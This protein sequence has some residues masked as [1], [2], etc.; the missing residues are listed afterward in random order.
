MSKKP[1]I[2]FLFADD[3]RYDTIHA[4]GNPEIITPNLDELASNGTTFNNAHIPGGSFAAVC[5]PSRAMLN[6]GRSLFHLKDNGASIPEEHTCLG[7]YLKDNGYNTFGTGKWH[8]CYQSYARSFN[9]GAEIFFGGMYDHWKVPVYNFDP[10]GQYPKVVNDVMDPG[11][12]N[13]MVP[14]RCDHSNLGV[15]STDLFADAACNYIQNYNDSE[16]PFYMYVAYMA[17]H[18][19]R[20]MPQEFRDMYDLDKISL[21]PNFYKEHPFDFGVSNVRDEALLSTPRDEEEVKMQIRDYYAMISHLDA[22]IG[23]IIQ[24]LKDSGMYDDTIIVFSADNGLA[25]GQHGLLGKQSTY[26][27]SIRVPFIISGPSIPKNERRDSYIY[28]MDI[29]PT[30]CSYAQIEPPKSVEGISFKNMIEDSKACNRDML[31]SVYADKVR[32]IKDYEY[33]LI[34]YKCVDLRKTQLFNLKDDPWEMNDLSGLEEMQPRIHALRDKLREYAIAWDDMKSEEGNRFWTEY[35]RV[36]P[37]K[38]E[39]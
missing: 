15:H 5:Q 17:P 7:E 24:T 1:N 4:V 10:T 38:W 9:S 6:S 3:M 28:L 35:L 20:S 26:E 18:D 34:E 22:S 12:D 33:K 16:K 8:N 36:T 31:Y 30:L 21:P 39:F 2:L 37:D 13:L 32:S 14:R 25:V 27:H 11:Y 29:F 23:R 19:P